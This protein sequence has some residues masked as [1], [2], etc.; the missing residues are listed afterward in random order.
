MPADVQL[1][2]VRQFRPFRWDIEAFCAETFEE[3]GLPPPFQIIDTSGGGDPV[4]LHIAIHQG[5]AC[6]DNLF[7]PGNGFHLSAAYHCPSED[8]SKL[9]FAA[10]MAIM[11]AQIDVAQ[12]KGLEGT[13]PPE[14]TQYNLL[15]CGVELGR[16]EAEYRLKAR[17][18]S[19]ALT[20]QM[21]KDGRSQAGRTTDDLYH[22]EDRSKV[23][24]AMA[25]LMEQEGQTP[26]SAG[27]TVYQELG[28]GSSGEANY[29]RWRRHSKK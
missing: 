25:R 14:S 28:L 17:N 3:E 15:T 29:Q 24:S 1:D 5:S 18:E 11:L 9:W 7:D 27:F 13:I 12:L 20:G 21:V 23:L 19:R 2:P 26:R 10:R 6:L 16:L 4:E 22:A 8:H